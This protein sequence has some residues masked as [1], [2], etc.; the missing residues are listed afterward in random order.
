HAPEYY[1]E[2]GIMLRLGIEARGIDRKARR[3]LLSD[4]SDLEYGAL[5]L[6]TGARPRTLPGPGGQDHCLYL[7]SIEDSRALRPLLD[8]G[9][10]L[11][12]IG[13]GFIGLEVAA[14]AVSR[15]CAVTVVEAGDSPLGRVAPPLLRDYY[16]DLHLAR[17]VDFRFGATVAAIERRGEERVVALASGEA[18]VADLVVAG[19]GVVPNSELAA[20]AGLA[21]S[22]GIDVDAFGA[23]AD[24]YIFAAGDVAHHYNP[25]LGR[26]IRLESWQ[27]AQNQAIAIARNLAGTGDPAPYAELPWFWSDQ[28]DV[29]LQIYGLLEQGGDLVVRGDPMGRSWLLVQQVDGRVMFAAGINA[30]RDLRP[31]REI[32]KLG[33]RIDPAALADEGVTTAQLLKTLKAAAVT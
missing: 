12:V 16:R 30:A 7:R 11:V 17:G 2:Q 22:D 24:P 26:A 28:Y 18:L 9:R 5:L 23:T 10:R 3:V 1:D 33:L 21:V 4:G 8:G 14:A 31:V 27:N 15:G 6:A 32:M 19:I 29:N 13:A 20:E 25:L